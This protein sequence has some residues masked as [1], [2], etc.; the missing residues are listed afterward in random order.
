MPSEDIQEYLDGK[1]L[2]GDDFNLDEIKRWFE[3][4]KEGYA[5]LG[6][7]N[8]ERYRFISCHKL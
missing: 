8:K 6:A 4:E 2:Y 1:K 7:K 3:D 5:N